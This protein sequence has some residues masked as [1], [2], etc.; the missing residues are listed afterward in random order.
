[1]LRGCRAISYPTGASTPDPFWVSVLPG[2]DRLDGIRVDN[3]D[4]YSLFPNGAVSS[5]ICT[6][7]GLG[8]PLPTNFRIFLSLTDDSAPFNGCVWTRFG[9]T[10]RGNILLTKYNTD[11]DT[12]D[13][14]DL[15]ELPPI[16]VVVG[17]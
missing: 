13:N 8:F 16:H 6:M 2:A 7:P 9:R 17:M 12:I 5:R 3:L 14:I 10:W 4:L 11:G 1:M 15:Y